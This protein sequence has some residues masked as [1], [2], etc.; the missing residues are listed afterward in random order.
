ME[1]LTRSQVAAA[2]NVRIETV[3]YYEQRGLISK[4]PRSP[5]GYRL[6]TQEAVEDIR[7]IKRAQDIG[8]TLEEIRGLLSVYKNKGYHPTEEMYQSTVVKI[9]EIDDKIIQLLKFKALLESVT[10]IP[11]SNLPLPKSQCPVLQKIAKGESEH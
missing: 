9:R 3:R 10:N 4:P 5:A 6:F 2:S 8:F 1:G 7:L 11:V